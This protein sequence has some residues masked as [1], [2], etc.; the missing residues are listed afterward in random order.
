MLPISEV[1]EFNVLGI[2]DFNSPG[3]L[4]S[5]YDWIVR[6]HNKIDG[7]ILEAGVFRGK[8]LLA[9]GL[10]LKKLGSNKKVFGFDS[11]S[12]FPPVYHSNDELSV[13]ES[14][15]D[16]GAISEEH[17]SKHLKL[18]KYRSLLK[19]TEVTVENIS[20]SVDFSDT[21]EALIYRKA[22]MLG[23]DNIEIIKGDFSDTMIQ[24]DFLGT[25]LMAGLLDCDLYNSY[26]IALPFIWERLE[27]NGM[28][29]LDEYY[30][31]KFPGARIACDEFFSSR[32]EKPQQVPTSP[33]EF[34]RWLAFK[35]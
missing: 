9:T 24:E 29:F 26:K 35:Q 6:N 16:S 5:Y 20:S 27:S 25:K 23:L 28:V 13:F 30:S 32:I 4:K 22:E 15:R 8:S 12:G 19:D 33:R 1:W 2:Y 31:L 17:Y 11:F 10:L 21:S 18:K 34:E 7:D 14:L 3:K